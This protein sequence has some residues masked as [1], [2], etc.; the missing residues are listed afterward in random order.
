MAT[1]IDYILIP[2][3][4]WTIVH[5]H[6]LCIDV[7]PSDPEVSKWNQSRWPSNCTGFYGHHVMWN[8]S[9]RNTRLTRHNR[10]GL[11]N[12][13]CPVVKGGIDFK[14]FRRTTP[15]SVGQIYS[16]G[17]ILS[18]PDRLA[19]ALYVE[20][21]WSLY[22]LLLPDIFYWSNRTYCVSSIAC[23]VYHVCPK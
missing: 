14:T 18:W 6:A 2:I 20:K 9:I 11:I 3:D 16:F 21:S 8:S 17:A 13:K 10:C 15:L 4:L 22:H 1:L 12:R 7:I 23:C 5:A 19:M